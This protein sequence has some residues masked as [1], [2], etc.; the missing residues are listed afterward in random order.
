VAADRRTIR[1][2]AAIGAGIVVLSRPLDLA[3][4]MAASSAHWP[5]G[6]DIVRTRPWAALAS[7]TLA[8]AL[9]T[10]WALV[11]ERGHT[12]DARRRAPAVRSYRRAWLA[13]ASIGTVAVLA[14][15]V[16]MT[17]GV[18]SPHHDILVQ[19]P[20]GTPSAGP[21]LPSTP[22]GSDPTASPTTSHPS[23]TPGSGHPGRSD[24]LPPP[25]GAGPSGSRPTST[26]AGSPQRTTPSAPPSSRAPQG[27]PAPTPS[28]FATDLAPSATKDATVGTCQTGGGAD[29]PKSLI[30]GTGIN[31][32]GRW[33]LTAP[34]RTHRLTFRGGVRD[35]P[36][37]NSAARVAIFV[38]VGDTSA[39]GATSKPFNRTMTYGQAVGAVTITVVPG[40]RVR[41]QA[42]AGS[43]PEDAC[44]QQPVFHS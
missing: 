21:L 40:Q 19:P 28:V 39:T 42:S 4:Q 12:P 5:A 18:W 41:F 37:H 2:R 11:V 13:V 20:S 16:A 36:Q 7:L 9:L 26:S 10:V 8:L 34:A 33:D 29:L 43:E 22:H 14:A 17:F 30:I 31:D 3:V 1:R 32:Y 44:I 35:S 38:Q 15:G 25:P 23:P 6:L 27:T 24:D